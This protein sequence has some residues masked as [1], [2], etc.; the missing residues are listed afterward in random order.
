MRPGLNRGMDR[1]IHSLVRAGTVLT[2]IL[3][4]L[5]PVATI[6]A[7]TNDDAADYD[8]LLQRALDQRNAGNFSDAEQNLRA[9][10]VLAVETSEIDFLLGMV[11][12]F[13]EKFDESMDVLSKALARYPDDIQLQLA[14]ARV[15]SYQGRHY[16]SLSVMAAVLVRQPGNREAQMLAARVN[17]H[18]RNLRQSQAL[19]AQVLKT[20]PDNPEAL[21]GLA[22][23]ESALGNRDEALALLDQ[24]HAINPD[25]PDIVSRRD[26]LSP[27]PHQYHE[28]NSGLLVSSFDSDGLQR[29]SDRFLEY[30][31]R[32][33]NGNQL[34]VRSEHLQRFGARDLLAEVG[35]VVFW[36]KANPL[37]LAVAH[38]DDA[39][40]SPQK[41]VRLATSLPLIDNGDNWGTS[42]LDVGVQHAEYHTG[43]VR[44][45][46]LG[47]THYFSGFNGWF[48]GGLL[49]VED[50]NNNLS[51][52]WTS[53]LHWQRT[54]RIRI[55]YTYTD[56][57]DTENNIT[58]ETRAHH[59][60]TSYRFS[61]R[62][63][64]R[65]DGARNA[66]E[67]SY[68]RESLGV[69]LQVRF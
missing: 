29:W 22:D 17:F 4:S 11:L 39:D 31:Y 20:D 12:A 68:T 53:G 15:L 2:V 18:A 40:F 46:R 10:R 63:T 35:A 37:E 67:N 13:Q 30:R 56:A 45:L 59:L 1:V 27:A 44:L 66:R 52:G 48:N 32:G 34:F 21:L 6:Q 58:T 7:D 60:Y 19:Y 61:D 51:S 25:D 28:I 65:L 43:T 41:R 5:M 49:R 24:A 47:I 3:F 64:L 26:A 8:T 9:A 33:G 16:E 36:G 23:V 14:K 38:G 69:S 42:L 54:A 62:L 55:G 50:E 57:P